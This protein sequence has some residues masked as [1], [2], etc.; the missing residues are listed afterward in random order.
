MM[1]G[2]KKP[3]EASEVIKIIKENEEKTMKNVEEFVKLNGKRNC[4]C[5]KRLENA[6][7]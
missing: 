2:L 1:S 4:D 7:L 6:R 3:V 5:N